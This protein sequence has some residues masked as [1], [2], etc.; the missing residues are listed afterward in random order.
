[1]PSYEEV[2]KPIDDLYGLPEQTHYSIHATLEDANGTAPRDS[3]VQV[4]MGTLK[5]CVDL[6]RTLPDELRP[7]AAEI[8]KD[9]FPHPQP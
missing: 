1:M 7:V 8:L 9:A 4:C 2:G 6:I 5:S 3:Y